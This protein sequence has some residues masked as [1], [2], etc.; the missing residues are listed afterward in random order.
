[1]VSRR[2]VIVGSL[3]IAAAAGV[4]SAVL[5]ES[6]VGSNTPAENSVSGKYNAGNE[7]KNST[8]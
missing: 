7:E 3:T 8:S 6:T 4:S 1:M 2:D 5:S